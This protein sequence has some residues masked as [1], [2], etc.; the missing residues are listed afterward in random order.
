MIGVNTI[1]SSS[2]STIGP[3]AETEYAVEPVD[4]AAIIPSA[5]HCPNEISLQARSKLIA[6]AGLLEQTT[7]SFNPHPEIIS[8]P[9]RSTLYES[10]LLF[11]IASLP[12]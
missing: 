10:K 7:I 5:L 12:L 6:R 2:G 3:P 1:A 8:A 11:S 4:D 9:S